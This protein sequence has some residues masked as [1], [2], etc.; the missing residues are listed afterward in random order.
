MREEGGERREEKG[1]KREGREE[2][3]SIEKP[4]ER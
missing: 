4:N 2:L 3:K 1:E